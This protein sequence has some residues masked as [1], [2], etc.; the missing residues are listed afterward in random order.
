MWLNLTYFQDEFY[1]ESEL[2]LTDTIQNYEMPTQTSSGVDTTLIGTAVK[3]TIRNTKVWNYTNRYLLSIPVLVSYN[4]ALRSKSQLGF[5]V[6]IEKYI[7][8]KINGMALDM[9]GEFYDLSTDVENR[10]GTR[11]VNVLLRLNYNYQITN[12]WDLRLIVNYK[13]ALLSNYNISAPIQKSFNGLGIG[14]GSHIKF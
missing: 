11:G 3:T 10:Y 12:N 9:N 2:T 4:T 14:I 13:N 8:T 1:N 7:F 6:G 5:G